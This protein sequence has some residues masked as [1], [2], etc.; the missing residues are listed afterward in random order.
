MYDQI[1]SLNKLKV[2]VY[3]VPTSNSS[4][5]VYTHFFKM[6][7]MIECGPLNFYMTQMTLVVRVL[8]AVSWLSLISSCVL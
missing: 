3:I 2:M 4:S 6:M 7:S 5:Y 1:I 8:T